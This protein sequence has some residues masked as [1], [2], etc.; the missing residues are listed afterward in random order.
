MSTKCDSNRL[1][2]IRCLILFSGYLFLI[3][4]RRTNT[5]LIIIFRLIIIMC[6]LLT[7]CHAA[8]AAAADDD[9]NDG[10]A[11]NGDTVFEFGF[12][13]VPVLLTAGTTIIRPITEAA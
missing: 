12:D 4:L 1:Q 8:A 2:V 9:Y 13:C 5:R 6:L 3:N 11:D 7:T 10:G